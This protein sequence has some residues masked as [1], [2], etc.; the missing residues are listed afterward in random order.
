MRSACELRDTNLDPVEAAMDN[1]WPLRSGKVRDVRNGEVV[2]VDTFTSAQ[3]VE[4]FWYLYELHQDFAGDPEQLDTAL[5]MLKT[6]DVIPESERQGSMN[7]GGETVLF[8]QAV[9]AA[10]ET[11]RGYDAQ[12]DRAAGEDW[13]G[14]PRI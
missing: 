13:G 9:E 1:Y 7:V 3:L 5:T 2:S 8:Q 14:A 6:V 4:L 12:M 11:V 10:R